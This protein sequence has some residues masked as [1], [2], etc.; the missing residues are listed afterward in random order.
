MILAA[1]ELGAELLMNCDTVGGRIHSVIERSDLIICDISDNH[2][3]ALYGLGCAHSLKKPTVTICRNDSPPHYILP[4]IHVLFYDQPSLAKTFIKDLR[5][6]IK[7][8]LDNPE[9]WVLQSFELSENA[10]SPHLFISYSHKD[11]RFLERLQIHLKPLERENLIELWDDT[12]LLAGDKWKQTIEESLKKARVAI[13]L[14][15]ADFLASDF[16]VNNELPPLLKDAKAKGTIIIPIIVNS[17]RFSRDKNLS[18]FH[19][20]NDPKNPIAKMPF[21]EQEEV[22]DQVSELVERYIKTCNE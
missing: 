17:C 5:I 22:F 12:K 10:V 16:I 3:D 18:S 9:K 21:P 1:E 20:I 14:I 7:S 6:A 19:A 8:A 2:G 11:K 4:K 15:S 13:L